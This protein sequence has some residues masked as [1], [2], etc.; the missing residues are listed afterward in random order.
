MKIENIF[1]PPIIM[2]HD[3]TQVSIYMGTHMMAPENKSNRIQYKNLMSEALDQIA[4]RKTRERIEMQLLS[5]YSDEDFWMHAKKGLAILVDTHDMNI[6]R[7]NRLFKNEV[8]V[9]DSFNLK[10][11]LRHF[12]SDDSFFILGLSKENFVVYK[13]NRYSLEKVEFDKNLEITKDEVLGTQTE[14]KT[15]IVSNY[16]GLAG[17]N[18]HGHNARSEEE[19]IDK[20]RYYLYIDRFIPKHLDNS[21]NLP[22]ILLGLTEHQGEFRKISKNSLILEEGVEVSLESIQNNEK[23]ILEKMWKVIEPIYLEKTK[24]L[25][26]RFHVNKELEKASAD[27]A[28]IALAL[29]EGRVDTLVLEDGKSIPNNYASLKEYK[30][31]DDVLNIFLELANNTNAKVVVLPQE[32]MPLDSGAFAIY[33]Y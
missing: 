30:K 20:Q 10:P 4:D 16:G 7:V 13:A 6:Y 1:P 5:V 2:N 32:K 23:E 22:I 12:Q 31:E 21:E 17:T 8:S 9:G 28:E 18:Y 26:E 25:L 11:L 33:R 27:I 19:K 15:L 24:T 3:D 29:L 14:G